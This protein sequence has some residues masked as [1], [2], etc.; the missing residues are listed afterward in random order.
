MGR[1]Q[2]KKI[3]FTRTFQD[4]WKFLENYLQELEKNGISLSQ[5]MYYEEQLQDYNEKLMEQF[6]KVYNAVQEEQN[7]KTL[8]D[9]RRQ[10]LDM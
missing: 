7:E 1:Y 9:F 5:Q 2:D 10:Y 4:L 3:E 8:E 6:K